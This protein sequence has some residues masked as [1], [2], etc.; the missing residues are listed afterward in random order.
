MDTGTSTTL[1][2]GLR[3]HGNTAAWQRFDECY[4]PM[5]LKF[6]AKL[7]LNDHDAQDAAQDTITAFIEGYRAGRYDRSR[8]RLRSWLFAIAQRKILDIRGKLGREMVLSD[9]TDATGFLA[10]VPDAGSLEEAWNDE[11]ERHRLQRCLTAIEP[12]FDE[13]TL[14]AFRLYVIAD[15]PAERVADHLGMTENAVYGAKHRV[16]NR[17]R[18]IDA[19]LE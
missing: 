5:V 14:T 16:L 10:S 18:E 12:D 8:G 2:E 1:L 4:R 3:D 15:W 7:G 6:A 13:R 11:W 17:I 9:R 19:R